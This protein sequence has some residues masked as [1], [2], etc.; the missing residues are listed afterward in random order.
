MTPAGTSNELDVQ[1]EW[2]E[3]THTHCTSYYVFA[4]LIIRR[5]ETGGHPG[6][7]KLITNA[8]APPDMQVSCRFGLF[9]DGMVMVLCMDRLSLRLVCFVGLLLVAIRR[10]PS[11]ALR[12]IARLLNFF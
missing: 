6:D 12:C 1:N 3:N 11:R 7:H 5:E 10:G 4:V 2:E 9:D 8:V